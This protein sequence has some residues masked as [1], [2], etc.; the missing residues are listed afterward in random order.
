MSD[1][2]S[3]ILSAGAL[4]PLNHNHHSVGQQLSAF[5]EIRNNEVVKLP[6]VYMLAQ[7]SLLQF[8]ATSDV[9]ACLKLFSDIITDVRTSLSVTAAFQQSQNQP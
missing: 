3:F 9:K 5:T 4:N 6:F 2:I 8:V 7:F 1:A